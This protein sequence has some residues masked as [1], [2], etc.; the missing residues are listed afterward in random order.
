MIKN[1][2]ENRW[3]KWSLYVSVFGAGAVLFY[4]KSIRGGECEGYCDVLG[5]IGI[6]IFTSY[7]LL[8]C[9]H[10][11][12]SGFMR[13]AIVSKWRWLA[14]VYTMTFFAVFFAGRELWENAVFVLG[15]TGVVI[16]GYLEPEFERLKMQNE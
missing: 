9:A 11:A 1:M 8:V 15:I 7:A 12:Q 16:V 13:D 2:M 5:A 4:E 6:T 10:W 14:V 3:Y